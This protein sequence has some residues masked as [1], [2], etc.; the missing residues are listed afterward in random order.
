M[1]KKQKSLGELELEVLK[2]IWDRKGG[3]IQ[4]VFEILSERHEYARTTVLTVMQRLYAKGFLKR[5]KTKGVFRYLPTQ[6][7]RKVMSNIIEQFVDK[8]L[9]GSAAPFLSYLS[10]AKGLTN[11]QAEHLRKIAENIN[12]NDKEK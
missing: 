4:E 7:E 2:I 5:R 6:C 11:K 8:F 3:T 12:R 9:D 10:E 1:T